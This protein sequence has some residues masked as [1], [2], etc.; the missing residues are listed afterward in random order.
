MN[1]V[2]TK[3]R[4]GWLGSIIGVSSTILG[5]RLNENENSKDMLNIVM[6]SAACCMPSMAAFDEQAR[7]VIDKAISETGII[8]KITMVPA[9][10]VM[11]GGAYRKIMNDMIQMNNKGKTV[12]PAILINGMVVSYGVPKLE[13]MKKALIK[14]TENKS[15]KEK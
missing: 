15:N 7:K 9:T 3:K 11:F 1:K 2:I 14:F 4:I 8:A 12:A 13:D 5:I 10:S 6:I